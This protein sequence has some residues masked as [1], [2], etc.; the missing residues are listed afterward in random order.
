VGHPLEAIDLRLKRADQHLRTLDRKQSAF[1]DKED[2]SIGG[3]FDANT[4]EYVFRVEGEMPDPRIGLFVGEFAHNLR[5][6]LDNLVWQLVRLRGGSPTRRT[7]FPIYESRKRYRDRGR[8][9]LR[10]VSADDRA[11]IEVIQPFEAGEGAPDTYLALL[12]WLNNVD[13]HRF[14]HVGCAM[15]VTFMP[16]Y[17]TPGGG[18]KKRVPGL[19]PWNPLPLKDVGKV[20]DVRYVPPVASYDRA[21]LMRVRIRASGPDPQMEVKGSPPLQIALSDP[22]HALILSDLKVMRGLVASII[23]GFRPRFD[24]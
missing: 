23:D 11:A 10:G 13:K 7:E 22:K 5:A 20:L 12:A 14:L 16:M 21:E 2:R 4:S 18:V 19:F 9:A 6:A 24:I 3:Y 1:L 15:P 17:Y 8:G